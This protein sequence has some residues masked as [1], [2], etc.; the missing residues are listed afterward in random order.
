MDWQTRQKADPVTEEWIKN[1]PKVELHVHLEGAI[2]LECLWELI[3]KYGGDDRV[4]HQEALKELFRYRDFPHF[5]SLWSWKNR[6]L[7][8][9]EDFELI[10]EAFAR[11]AASQRIVYS[12]AFYSPGGFPGLSTQGITE[13]LRRGL[14][15]V[16]EETGKGIWA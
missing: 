1:I 14:N 15:K 13:T 2:P 9:Y 7:R 10:G 11:A 3:L 6:F 5:L 16:P 4:P 8:Q 12:E